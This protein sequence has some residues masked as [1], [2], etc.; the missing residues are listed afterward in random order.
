MRDGCTGV[1]DMRRGRPCSRKAVSG[2]GSA[3]N[4]IERRCF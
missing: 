1:V 2:T 4:A 3:F